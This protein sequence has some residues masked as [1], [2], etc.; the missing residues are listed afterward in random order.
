MRIGLIS[1]THGRLRPEVFDRLAGVELI[2]HA[3]D[4]GSPDIITE[5]ETIAP[6]RAVHGNTDDFDIRERYP[7]TVS[8]EV[9]GRRIVLTHGHLLGAPTPR[10]L[11]EAH[12]AADI[13]IYGHTHRPLLDA[14]PPL[15]ANPGA[16]GPARF[17]LKPN[18]AV[19]ETSSLTIEFLEL[20]A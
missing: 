14:G 7:E 10:L 5:L 18:V 3:G 6:V 9:D 1:D 15:V 16:A 8:L 17:H 4:I 12:P 11:R 19:L 2:L 13:I 20:T